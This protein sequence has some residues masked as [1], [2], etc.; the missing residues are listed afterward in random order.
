MVR[1][2]MKT[3]ILS[4][5]AAV[6][7]VLT[8]LGGLDLSGIVHL[9]PDNVATGLA[10][11]LPGLAAVVHLVNTLAD[12]IDDGKINGSWSPKLYPLC[13]WLTLGLLSFPLVSCAGLQSGF[14]GQPILTTPVQRVDGSG[15][16]FDVA[17]VD[18]LRA[19]AQPGQAWGLYNAGALASQTAEVVASGK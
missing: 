14:T 16:P 3:R 9:F 17:T 10:T 11:V 7:A 15:H 13:M 5:L 18:V 6:A 1:G 19:E 12:A 8:V 2:V 4:F